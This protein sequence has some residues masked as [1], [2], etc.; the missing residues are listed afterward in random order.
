VNELDLLYEV[1]ASPTDDAFS[2]CGGLA[3][4]FFWLR[5]VRSELGRSSRGSIARW[6]VVREEDA[7]VFTGVPVVP[8]GKFPKSPPVR[9]SHPRVVDGLLV[10]FRFDGC[11]LD[12][13]I[14]VLGSSTDGKGFAWATKHT[15]S[16][17]DLEVVVVDAVTADLRGVIRT[18]AEIDVSNQYCTAVMSDDEVVELGVTWCFRRL[19][20]GGFAGSLRGRLV[21]EGAHPTDTDAVLI[22]R[23]ST[24]AEPWLTFDLRSK[25]DD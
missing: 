13:V 20:G 2:M 11:R 23:D 18:R 7:V 19:V 14:A 24:P 3:A 9:L 10:D 6:E 5:S 12:D 15:P 17:P 1:C 25:D 22:F 4:D 16:A 21:D 8:F